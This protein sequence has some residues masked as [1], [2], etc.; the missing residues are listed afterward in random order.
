MLRT[1]I[2]GNQIVIRVFSLEKVLDLI[3][4]KEHVETRKLNLSALDTI[5]RSRLLRLTSISQPETQREM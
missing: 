1:K 3:F 5:R 2:K 4:V